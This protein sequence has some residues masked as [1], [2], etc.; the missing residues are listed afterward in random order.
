MTK[1]IRR[2]PSLSSL[3]GFQPR[4]ASVIIPDTGLRIPMPGG[5][6][7]PADEPAVPPA[8]PSVKP[9]APESEAE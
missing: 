5:A 2:V 6:V 7:Q 4:A 9:D 3:F 8:A 1:D